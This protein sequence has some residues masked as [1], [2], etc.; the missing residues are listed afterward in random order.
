MTASSSQ[1]QPVATSLAAAGLSLDG[2]D[3]DAVARLYQRFAG[4]RARLTGAARPESEPMTIPA[5]DRFT[6]QEAGDERR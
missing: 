6:N 2:G 5:F 1:P 4:Q 3:L